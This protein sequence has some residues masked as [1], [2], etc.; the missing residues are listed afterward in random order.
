[1]SLTSNPIIFPKPDKETDSI[2][3]FQNYIKTLPTRTAF[4]ESDKETQTK[5]M[6]F[7]TTTASKIPHIFVNNKVVDMKSVSSLTYNEPSLAKKG[8]II[9]YTGNQ[10]AARSSDGGS[11]WTYVSLPN[12][13]PNN[14]D[15]HVLYDFSH[16]IFIWYNQGDQDSNGEN[17]IRIS[18]SKDA[19]HWWSYDIKP[20]DLNNTWTRQWFDYPQLALSNNYLYFTSDLTRPGNNSDDIFRAVIVRI[21]IDVLINDKPLKYDYFDC[22]YSSCNGDFGPV[23]GATDTMYFAAKNSESQMI[24]YEWPES[25]STVKNKFVRDIPNTN[26]ANTGRIF[27]A[28]PDGNNWC[29]RSA[30]AFTSGWKIGNTIGFFWTADKGN[31]FPQPFVDSATFRVSDMKYLSRPSLW[32]PDYAWQFASAF[33]NSKGDLGIIAFYGGGKLNPS[34]A[35]GIASDFNGT[36]Q[37]WEMYP[38]VSGTNGPSDSQWGD[39]LTIRPYDKSRPLWVASAFTL[40]G[41]TTVYSIEPRYLV[42]GYENNSK[43]SNESKPPASGL[44]SSS[45]PN[46]IKNNAKWWSQGQIDDS[47]FVKGIQYMIQNGIMKIPQTQSGSSS[48]QQIPSWI[49]NNAGWWAN[50][51]ISDDEFVRGIQYLISTG[52][53]QIHP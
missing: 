3:I 46:W 14:A 26:L 15:Q 9:F 47:E 2:T 34:V 24:L 4:A 17:H 31:G 30:S 11:S 51:K 36:L 32:S 48:S 25:S 28:G 29:G 44:E 38:V 35:I 20:T 5:L 33:P 45:I 12:D 49:K 23:Q 10:Y 50:G 6:D 18:I 37:H 52:T 21:P 39:Y 7:A 16:D 53:I 19:F 27:C 8:N 41:G 40:Q 22:E 1:M 42:F 13:M 43:T